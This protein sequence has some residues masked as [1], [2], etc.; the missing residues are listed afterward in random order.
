MVTKCNAIFA[1]TDFRTR[2]A[3]ACSQIFLESVVSWLVPLIFTIVCVQM[4][5]A[6]ERSHAEAHRIALRLA[7]ANLYK[8]D[9]SH[10]LVNRINYLHKLA[11]QL[12]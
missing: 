5:V 11:A 8:E 9:T 10:V 2:H 3:D 6:T 7:E 4:V 12:P 1:S